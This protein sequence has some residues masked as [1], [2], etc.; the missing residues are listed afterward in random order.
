MG[1]QYPKQK[2]ACLQLWRMRRRDIYAIEVL[3]IGLPTPV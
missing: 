1:V 3:F 2:T